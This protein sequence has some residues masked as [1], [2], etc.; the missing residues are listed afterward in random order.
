MTP[1]AQQ[2]YMLALE[3]ALAVGRLLGVQRS[4]DLLGNTPREAW[5][6]IHRINLLTK[7][8]G[9]LRSYIVMGGVVPLSASPAPASP[10]LTGFVTLGGA[11]RKLECANVVATLSNISSN[12]IKPLLEHQAA[13]RVTAPQA[14]RLQELLS[15]LFGIPVLIQLVDAVAIAAAAVFNDPHLGEWGVHALRESLL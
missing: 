1:S 10:A 4:R 2:V 5:N 11:L 7:P 12:E 15:S 9:L 6:P 14:K 3:S 8:S 13:Q